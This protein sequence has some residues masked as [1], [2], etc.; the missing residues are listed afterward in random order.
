VAVLGDRLWLRQGGAIANSALEGAAKI[1]P[2]LLAG[3]LRTRFAQ[4]LGRT[5][6]AM[7]SKYEKQWLSGKKCVLDKRMDGSVDNLM[8]NPAGCPQAAARA[9]HELTH[10]GL[11]GFLTTRFFSLVSGGAL[12]RQRGPP[13]DVREPM[14]RSVR[15][16]ANNPSRE[17]SSF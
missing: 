10:D 11:F 8:D 12:S 1:G 7:E 15:P 5:L 2:L 6:P 16:F 4:E 17:N 3:A 14:R 9:A 13:H